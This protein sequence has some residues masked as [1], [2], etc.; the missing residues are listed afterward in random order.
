MASIEVDELLTIVTD[1]VKDQKRKMERNKLIWTCACVAFANFMIIW[2]WQ[3][4][5]GDEFVVDHLGKV[6]LYF[7]G[8]ALPNVAAALFP[9]LYMS[10]NAYMRNVPRK[11]ESG[12]KSIIEK[13]DITAEKDELS[14]A[15]T[16]AMQGF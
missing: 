2:S 15:I 5:N 9:I 13:E 12:V 16:K 14:M 3:H 6:V 1:L 10:S 11:I 8:W 4:S 7:F